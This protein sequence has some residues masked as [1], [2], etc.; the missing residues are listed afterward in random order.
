MC[1]YFIC[2]LWPAM[3]LGHRLRSVLTLTSYFASVY[4]NDKGV[5]ESHWKGAAEI[6]LGLCTKYVNQRGEVQPLSSEKVP[7]EEDLKCEEQSF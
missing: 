5:V 6:I 1:S 3:I 2:G 7:I 4:Q